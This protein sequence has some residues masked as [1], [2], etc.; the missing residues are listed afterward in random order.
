MNV[1]INDITIPVPENA[2]L[3]DALEAKGI[4]PQGIATAV[5]GTVIP[6][7]SRADTKLNEGDK[8]VFIKAFY[9]G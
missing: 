5:N 8:I 9:G 2:T 3:L 7:A 6:S 1:T 4:S